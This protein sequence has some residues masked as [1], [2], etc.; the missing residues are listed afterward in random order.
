MK[1]LEMEFLE[2]DESEEDGESREN[3]GSPEDDYSFM[4]DKVYEC[5]EIL[6]EFCPSLE[7]LTIRVNGNM[8]AAPAYGRWEFSRAK[9][10]VLPGF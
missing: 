5:F 10:L 7:S 6:E 3:M 9:L 2:M 1:R 4:Y 8:Y